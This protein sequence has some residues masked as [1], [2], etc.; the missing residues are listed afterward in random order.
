MSKCLNKPEINKRLFETA[1]SVSSQTIV[2]KYASA[3]YRAAI[4]GNVLR[5]TEVEIAKLKAQVDLEGTKITGLIKSPLLN[6]NQKKKLL[7]AYVSKLDLKGLPAKLIDLIEAN[8]RLAETFGIIQEFL[9]ICESQKQS[10]KVIVTSSKV[11]FR[12][13]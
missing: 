11:L 10:S 13:I 7:S 3:L 2:G 6:N 9:K 8:G 1:M 5:E 12:D 4:R